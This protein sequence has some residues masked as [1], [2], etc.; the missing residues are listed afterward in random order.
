M[1]GQQFFY[2]FF[3]VSCIKISTLMAKDAIHMMI[4]NMLIFD[5]APVFIGFL[6]NDSILSSLFSAYIPQKMSFAL[7]SSIMLQLSISPFKTFPISFFST[8]PHN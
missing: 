5:S 4:E 6:L 3:L 8:L 7:F 1:F 2:Y